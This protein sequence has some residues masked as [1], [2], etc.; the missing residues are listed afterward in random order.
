MNVALWLLWLLLPLFCLGI[1]Y[2]CVI[3]STILVS[4][5]L[6]FRWMTPKSNISGNTEQRE[7]D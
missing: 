3:V 5:G 4:S 7:E 2:L 1:F 6:L